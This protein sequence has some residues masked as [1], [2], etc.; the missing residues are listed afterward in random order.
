MW[1]GRR[2]LDFDSMPT[3]AAQSMQKV[4]LW[5]QIAWGA[6]WMSLHRCQSPAC[7]AR[8]AASEAGIVTANGRHLTDWSVW[9]IQVTLSKHNH[10]TEHHV[11]WVH[12]T[13]CFHVHILQSSQLYEEGT[14][15]LFFRK[16]RLWREGGRHEI[17]WPKLCGQKTTEPGFKPKSLGCS[18]MLVC[19]SPLFRLLLWQ[20]Y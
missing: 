4:C 20:P 15:P 19:S 14:G 6:H 13:N 1:H 11:L 18:H 12:C 7:T 16:Q 3:G 9:E 17:G 2:Y 8:R 10:I 5:N